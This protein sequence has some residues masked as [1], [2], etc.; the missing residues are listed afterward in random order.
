[1]KYGKLSNG[2]ITYLAVSNIVIGDKR[3]FN[4]SEEML[5][6][7]GIYRVEDVNV[8]GSNYLDGNV[9]K[10]YIGV[11]KHIRTIEEAKADKVAEI[12]A[13]DT[14]SAVNSFTFNGQELWVDKATRVGLMNAIECYSI[15]D[16]EEITF[17]IGNMSITLPLA[18]AKGLLASLEAYALE[19]YNITLAHKNAV[20]ALDSIAEIDAYDVTV[21]YPAKL[22]L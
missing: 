10:H 20:M 5:N 18:Q 12:D 19:C 16:K 14:S 6:K 4:P 17:G 13:Y 1:M 2:E 22:E 3:V 11:A 21:G 8:V 15:L 9:I 7:V